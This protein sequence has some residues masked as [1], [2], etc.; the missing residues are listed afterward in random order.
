MIAHITRREMYDL[1]WAEPL[2]TVAGKLGISSWHLKDLCTRHR[3]PVP[4]PAYWRDKATGKDPR[5]TIFAS[6][7]DPTVELISLD[8]N[9]PTDSVVEQ[10][11]ERA[12]AAPIA[13]RHV[14]KPRVAN[15]RTIEWS[16]VEKPHKVVALTAHSLR[17]AK[18]DHDG[19]VEI[20]GE[21]L[22]T[23][24]LGADSIERVIFILDSVVR[25]LET[26]GM[27]CTVAGH[28]GE[29]ARHRRRYGQAQVEVHRGADKVPFLLTESIK[30][31]KH[32]PTVAELKAEE[33]YR[34]ARQRNWSLPYERQYPEFDYIP[35]G[36]LAISVEAYSRDQRRRNWRDNSRA[37]L[38]SRIK[39]IIEDLDGWVESARVGRLERER[40]HRVWQRAEEN[41]KRA[42]E[43]KKR[44]TARDNLV[45]E[46]VELGQK[47]EQLRSWIAWAGDIEDA[48]TR[49]MLSWA[50]ERLSEIERALDPAS[51]GDWLREH[52]LFPEIDP[53]AS[54]PEDPD[55]DTPSS[56]DSLP[57]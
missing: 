20:S 3:V 21:G 56:Q 18:P 19:I 45:D 49:R 5:K 36:E 8:P 7:D 28:S 13:L 30:R 57:A 44:E 17:R 37:T 6:S 27:T 29:I 33:R 35:T 43:R 48:E 54:L 4:A 25:G 1:V 15:P 52:K 16:P 11:L 23:L 50:R 38:E 42:E 53:F 12:R 22:L 41:R 47:A 40:S 34:L 10:R 32:E 14:V 39:D 51:F 55:L 26:R 2:D 46:I 31:Q 24:R 9:S